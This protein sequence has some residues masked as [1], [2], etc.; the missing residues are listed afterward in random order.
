M[1]TSTTVLLLLALTGL[2]GAA[3]TAV[4]AIG[5]GALQIAVLLMFFAP[6]QAIP[7]HGMVQLV[8]NF[9]RIALLWRHISWPIIWRAGLL[10]PLGGAAGIWLFQGLPQ[11][12]IELLIGS[13]ILVSLFTSGR[14][15]L[16]RGRDAPLWMFIPLG[17][18]LGAL[19]VTVAVVG[20]FSGPFMMR[21]DLK[22]EAINVSMATLAS[23]GHVTKVVAFGSMGFPP[24]DFSVEFAVMVPAAILGTLLG[25]RVLNRMSEEVFRWIFRATLAT[26][27]VKLIVWD[28]LLQP[29]LN[30]GA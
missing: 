18:A 6:A 28:G 10:I 14:M 21:K 15:K 27:A 26:L 1:A 23:M 9:S 25:E 2:L 19:S 4:A 17:F 12:A 3:I 7:F 30:G 24:W 20:M 11:R 5:G 13:F 16:F 29:F 22:K 8:G